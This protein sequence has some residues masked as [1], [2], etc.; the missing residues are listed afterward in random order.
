MTCVFLKGAT[1]M[2]PIIDKATGRERTLQGS[3]WSH[4]V[5]PGTQYAPSG[6]TGKYPDYDKVTGRERN[7]QSSS[8]PQG[9]PRGLACLFPLTVVGLSIHFWK[10]NKASL[11]KSKPI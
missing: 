1:G 7:L 10:C 3:S 5:A 9:C 6:I 4:E 8:S 11:E 2:C